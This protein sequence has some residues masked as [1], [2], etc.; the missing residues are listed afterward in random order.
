MTK[1][2]VGN[3]T[4]A[5]VKDKSGSVQRNVWRIR[6]SLGKVF[7][8]NTGKECYIYSPW[9][10]VHG[11]KEKARKALATYREELEN[12]VEPDPGE[13]LFKK[14]AAEF[15]ERRKSKNRLSESTLKHYQY[16]T[17][18][19]NVH[20]ADLELH[21]IDPATIEKTL[22]KIGESKPPGEVKRCYRM[23]NQ[24]LKQAVRD[25]VLPRNPCDKVDPPKAVRIETR[26]LDTDDV[27]RLL[28]ALNA[29]Q[30]EAQRLEETERKTK[31]RK[32]HEY[33]QG[34]ASG[35]LL[36][37]RAIAVALALASG[38][39]RGEVLGLT[40][41]CVDLEGH[42]IRIAQQLTD[43]GL[44]SPKTKQSR[45]IITLDTDTMARLKTWKEKQERF[46]SSY[47]I[48]QG[49]DTPVITN[50]I[51]GF[52]EPHGFSTWWRAFCA[53]NGFS[54]LRFHDL[55][56]THATLLIANNV[57]IKTVQGRLGHTEASTTLDIYS[58]IMPAKD[59]EAANTVGR[60]LS[61]PTPTLRVVNL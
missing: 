46:L 35:T 13:V 52:H 61:A 21:R 18:V 55:R 19:L 30:F 7:D 43:S 47:G 60:I 2:I 29:T 51:G 49:R 25:D 37:S 24:I 54:G 27:A 8:K 48:E 34:E 4:I 57:D 15:C 1:H 56:H 44:S 42:T 50:E 10:T 11:T 20:L 53:A 16:L 36:R 14:Y 23:L 59:K 41:G 17:T 32:Q 31:P 28:V 9:R 3:G 38:C 6:L 5:K 45:R 26:F 12:P 22:A 33:K 40:W 58:H 39:R